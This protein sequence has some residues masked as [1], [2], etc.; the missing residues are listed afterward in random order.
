MGL[1]IPAAGS[2]D[3]GPQ[4]SEL[5]LRTTSEGKMA[6]A[7]HNLTLVAEDWAGTLVIGESPDQSSLRVTIP[8]A[9]L[10]VRDAHGGVKPLSGMERGQVEKNAASTLGVS[11]Y[12][13]LTFTSTAIAGTW[14]QGRMEGTLTL[15]GRAE[16]QQFDVEAVD[17]GYRLSGTIRQSR[18]GIKPFSLM[19]G[20]LKVGDDVAVEVTV[21]LQ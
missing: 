20:A 1:M 13:D 5:L 17:G 18:Y 6:R 8:L 12:P 10:R 21:T 14:E 4:S 9:S 16:V 19:M 15:R 11:Q 3:L 2:Y 7:G